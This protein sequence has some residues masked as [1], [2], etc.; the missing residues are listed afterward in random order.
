M[1]VH[2]IMA[3]TSAFQA[4]DAGSI[5]AARSNFSL[6]FITHFL[7]ATPYSKIFAVC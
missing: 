5:P 2:R 1:C 6:S 3:I 4:D 7:P